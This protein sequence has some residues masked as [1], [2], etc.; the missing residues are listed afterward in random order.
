MEE[1]IVLLCS[2]VIEIFYNSKGMRCLNFYSDTYK[3]LAGGTYKIIDRITLWFYAPNA[4]KEAL[5]G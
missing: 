4:Y 2:F 5:G 1:T 3:K